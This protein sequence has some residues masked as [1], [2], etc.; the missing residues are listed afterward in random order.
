MCKELVG[1]LYH[2]FSICGVRISHG[3]MTSLFDTIAFCGVNFTISTSMKMVGKLQPRH[4]WFVIR[5]LQVSL[6]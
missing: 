4:A 3:K 2:R 6:E 5:N 1:L